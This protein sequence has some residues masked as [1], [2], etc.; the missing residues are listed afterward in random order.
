MSLTS[1]YGRSPFDFEILTWQGSNAPAF[2]STGIIDASTEKLACVGYV[3]HPSRPS[4]TFNIRKVHFRTGAVSVNASSVLRVSLQD[5]SLTA[6]PPYQPDGSQDQT[7]DIAGNALAAN[8][9]TT[10]GN[11]SADRAVSQGSRI[12]IVWE[13]QTFTAADSI[14][15]STIGAINAPDAVKMGGSMLLNTGSWA[16]VAN[17]LGNVV[18]ECDDGT[19]AFLMEHMAYSALGSASVASNGAIRAAGNYFTVPVEFQIDGLSLKCLLPNGCD[20]DLILYDGDGTTVLVSVP[21]D[22]DAVFSAG[23]QIARVTFAPITLRPGVGYRWAFVA[24]TTT[25]AT[26]YHGD[27][28]QAGMLDN[29]P[30]GRQ[31]H[32]TQRDSSGVWTETTTRKAH[33]GFGVAAIGAGGARRVH[34]GM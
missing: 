15:V 21:V 28:S 2:A 23:A 34:F 16:G 20:G 32:W 12:A 30:G 5:V 22:N 27:V 14:V 13:Y 1:L 3:W 24:G 7:A 11:L 4:G 33:W 8:T 9:W 17:S 29:T 10:T 18:L 31:A 19:Y 26:V 6:G 25:A